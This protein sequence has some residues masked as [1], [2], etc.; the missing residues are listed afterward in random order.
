MEYL[1][2]A[3]ALYRCWRIPDSSAQ[4]CDSLLS[5]WLAVFFRMIDLTLAVVAGLK[6]RST[7]AL[8]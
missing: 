5:F 6:H 8:A 4:I 2:I 1:R 7:E 3:G